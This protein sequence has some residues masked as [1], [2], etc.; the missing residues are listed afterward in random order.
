[1][2]SNKKPRKKYKPKDFGDMDPLRTAIA[3]TQTISA[4][5]QLTLSLPIR[6]AFE[7][8]I[9]GDG[10]VEDFHGLNLV[11]KIAMA[12]TQKIDPSLVTICKEAEQ[13]LQRTSDRYSATGKFGFDGLAINQIR[14]LIELYEELL[15]C[16]TPAQIKSTLAE[17]NRTNKVVN[18]P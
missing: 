14:A 16:I 11:C 13:A 9:K 5:Q 2:A 18:K 15:T 12:Q 3:R 7:A 8:F 6:V 17:I 1:M 4:S 10:K